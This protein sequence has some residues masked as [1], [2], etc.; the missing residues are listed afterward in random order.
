MVTPATII[1]LG[2]FLGMR[3]ALDPD[4][5]IAV[6]TIVSRERSLGR[7]TLIGGLW[8]IGHSVTIVIIGGAI[9]ISR[10]VLPPAAG[11][12][13]ELA[14]AAMLIV[15]GVQN[16]RAIG[17]HRHGDYI[18]HHEAE[19]HHADE[20]TPLARID[21]LF[22]GL[23]P[24]QRVRPIVVGVIHGLAGSAAVA[25]LIVPAIGSHVLAATYLGVFGAGTII[26]MMLMTCAIATPVV[27][28]H[29]RFAPLERK[30]AVGFS[31]ASIG[32]GLF[33]GLQ[34][35]WPGVFLH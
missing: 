28:A 15:L 23:T 26:G 33:L 29:R 14:V 4:H 1:L 17:F 10:L 6:S 8:G 21:R 24:Y 22:L 35:G 11:A 5:V 18:H 12:A 2:F 7:A 27:Y 19:H 3:H 13:M 30:L 34:A 31:L 32:F 9:V 16:L 20:Q 25:L